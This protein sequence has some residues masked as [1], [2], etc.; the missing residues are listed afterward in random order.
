MRKEVKELTHAS[1]NGPISAMP[2]IFLHAQAHNSQNLSQN[3]AEILISCPCYCAGVDWA[4][5]RA[6]ASAGWR[7]HSPRRPQSRTRGQHRLLGAGGR[8]DSQ[9][10]T[11]GNHGTTERWRIFKIGLKNT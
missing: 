2:C 6:A 3:Y 9:A 11:A 8:E 7:P 4:E 5:S 1:E 10:G